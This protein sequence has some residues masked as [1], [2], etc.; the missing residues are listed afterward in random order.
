MMNAARE[1]SLTLKKKGT[2]PYT[3]TKAELREKKIY[4]TLK[5]TD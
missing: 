4:K 5:V 2:A 3:H 1:S